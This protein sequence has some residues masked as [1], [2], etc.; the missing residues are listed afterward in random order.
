M[1]SPGAWLTAPPCGQDERRRLFERAAAG[2]RKA[3]AARL[4]QIADGIAALAIEADHPAWEVSVSALGRWYAL[5]RE[6]LDEHWH[7]GYRPML[8][9]DDPPRLR[10]VIAKFGA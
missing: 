7:A 6:P 8:G 2:R 9:A 10:A 4:G 3:L 1:V 5:R